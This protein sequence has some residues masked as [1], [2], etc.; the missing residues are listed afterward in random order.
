MRSVLTVICL[1]RCGVTALAFALVVPAQAQFATSGPILPAE[2][3]WTETSRDVAAADYRDAYCARWTDGCAICE[4]TSANEQPKCRAA[5]P[6]QATCEQKTIQCQALLKT[7]HRVCLGYF[8][9]CNHCALG[10]CTAMGCTTRQPDGTLRQKDPDYACRAP[11]RAR[12]DNL[13]S[14]GLDLHGHWRLT[15]PNGR[16]CEIV[17]FT[18]VALTPDCIALGEPVTQVRSARLSG[19]TFHL[20]TSKDEELL[21]FDTSD[22]N[23]LTG[24]AEAKGYRLT[25]LEAEPMDPRFWEGSWRLRNGGA[26]CDLFL[27]MRRHRVGPHPYV[28]IVHVPHGVSLASNCFSPTDSDIILFGHI[29]RPQ[30]V[31]PRWTAW[32]FEGHTITFRDDKGHH[33]TFRRTTDTWITDILDPQISANDLAVGAPPALT[34]DRSIPRWACPPALRL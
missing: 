5:N 20:A 7:V 34:G 24:I 17:N 8:D 1:L 12:Y 33:T 27:T 4:R 31:L 2:R 19:S 6:S 21:S 13:N 18:A 30:I 32:Q 29:E 15:D 3:T 16:A 23:D 11:R 22:L 25:R 14:L 10:Y 9:G 26:T 28:D